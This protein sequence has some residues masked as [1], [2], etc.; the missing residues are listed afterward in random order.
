MKIYRISY[1][2]IFF[3]IIA[4]PLVGLLWYEQP[5]TTENKEL[6]TAPVLYD[7]GIN[8]KYFSDLK[9]YYNDHFA[10][11]QEL[12]TANASI[13]ANI[14]KESSEDLAIVGKEDWL[15]LKVT[16]EDYQGTNIASA[17]G[18]NNMVKSVGL[19]QEYVNGLGASFVFTCAPNKNTLYPE[20]MPY[21]YAV[22]N[23]V[24]NLDLIT[25]KLLE[26]NINYYDAR[27]AFENEKDILYHR[28]DSHWDNRGA[29]MVQDGVLD[30]AE[31]EHTDYTQLKYTV[32]ESFRG[33]IYKILYPQ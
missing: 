9:D 22:I 29:A 26:S 11:R 25:P 3:I 20:Y 15:F 19:M 16:L 5:E 32:S 6:A 18:I 31:V 1:I 21:Y 27:A 8:L 7:D 13:K 4:L 33:D 14:F 28:G 30:V 2:A 24:S 17:R 12:V 10:Y 23:D